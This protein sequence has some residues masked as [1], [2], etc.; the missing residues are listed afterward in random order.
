MR[1]ASSLNFYKRIIY[2]AFKKNAIHNRIKNKIVDYLHLKSPHRR[3]D[4]FLKG[5]EY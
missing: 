3:T 1:F 2:P 5:G 4:I